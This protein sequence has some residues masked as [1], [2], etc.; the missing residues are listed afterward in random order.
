MTSPDGN[1]RAP[2]GA[3]PITHRLLRG[4]APAVVLIVVVGL[5]A[6]FVPSKVPSKA[7]AF[8]SG[9]PGASGPAASNNPSVAANAA[10]GSTTTAPSSGTA[11]HTVTTPGTVAACSGQ[12]EQVPGDPY[13]PPCITFSGSNGGATSKGVSASTINVTARLTTDQSFQQT[14]ATLAGAQLRDTNADNERTINALVQYF[15]S[16]FQF[17]GRKIAVKYY[18]GQGSLSNELQ[19]Y[20]QAQ[21]EVDANSAASMGS[22]ADVTAESEPYAT[23]LWQDGV[24]GFGDPYMPNSWHINHAP[25]DWSLATDG[26]DLATDAANYVVQKLCPAGTPAA[27]AG[28][29]LKNAPR[30]F[31]NIAP[32]NELYQESAKIFSQIMAAHGCVS[33]SFQYSLDLGTESQ[34]A[35]NLVAQLKA[36]GYTTI[37]CGCDPI[38]PVYLSGQAAQQSFLPEFVE[39]G[40]ALVDQ[41][42]VG[43]LYNQS[44]FSHAFG[45]SPNLA[46][47]PYTQT[48]GYAAYKTVNSDEPAFFVNN[49]YLQLDQLAI[50]I[51]MAGPDLTPA[52]FQAGMYKYPA[53]LGPAGLWAFSPTQHTIPNDFREVCWSPNTVSP[54]NGKMGAYI[55]TSNQRWTASDI[56]KGPPGCPIPSS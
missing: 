4:Y 11:G 32:Q 43:Q 55:Q 20:G 27:L 37:V 19:G 2:V 33:N 28:G 13:S 15:N 18:T 7:S 36:G 56:P 6:L 31:A 53:K 10:G 24:M 5:I 38:F 26:T 51:Q 1:S 23:A 29:G 52:S 16:H 44:F 22:F 9:G 45:I 35:A 54:Y 17:Y 34:Q 14:L 3:F 48:L 12:T 25:Y 39:I 46:A 42:Y 21:A 30:K 40:A 41:D 50:G 8:G 49:I 47:V